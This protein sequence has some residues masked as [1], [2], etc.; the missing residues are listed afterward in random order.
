MTID[1]FVAGTEGYHTFRIPAVVRSSRGTLL[2]FAEGR[3]GGAGDA[4][5]IDLVLRRSFDGGRTFGPLIVVSRQGADTVGN[6]A[7]VVDPATGDIVLLSTRNAGSA[8]E[9]ALLGGTVSAAD[10]RR[11]LVQRSVDDGAS[12]TSPRDL[13][14]SVKLP[15]WRWYATGPCHGI[16]LH[17]GRLVV[18]ANH[19]VGTGYGGHVLLSDDGGRTWRIGAVDSSDDGVRANETTVAELPDG[20]LYFNTRNQHGAAPGTRAYARSGDGGES[21]DQPYA[22]L[23]ELVGPVVQGSVLVHDSRLLLSLPGDPE[24]RRGMAVRSSAD[25]GVTWRTE[26]EVSAAPAAY[27]DLVVLATGR[28][29][30]LF[31]TGRDGPYERIVFVE[32]AL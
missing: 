29:G 26:V 11:V 8:T 22:P 24:A 19:S 2:A 7:P 12:W 13:T 9:S 30:L 28:V 25:R 15:E 32:L 5:D 20:T 16:A 31:E 18:P 27:S 10:S 17:S 14:E 1:V 21:F 23:P 4:G 6:P 3:R